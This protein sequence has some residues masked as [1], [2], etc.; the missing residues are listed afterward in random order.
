MNLKLNMKDINKL[1]DR[2]ASALYLT[3]QHCKKTVP[4]GE[5]DNM[6]ST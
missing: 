3:R 2:M 4:E 6:F 5:D 1:P